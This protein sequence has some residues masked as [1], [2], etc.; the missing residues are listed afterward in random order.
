M[1]CGELEASIKERYGEVKR[2]WHD[3]RNDKHELKEKQKQYDPPQRFYMCC[4]DPNVVIAMAKSRPGAEKQYLNKQQNLR[5]LLQE[6]NHKECYK[7][8]YKT[9][10]GVWKVATDPI[11]EPKPKPKPSKCNPTPFVIPW[12]SFPLPIPS[13]MPMPMPMPVPIPA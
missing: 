7:K 12:P 3:L 2:R 5:D 6:F 1:D 13:P 11:P 8:G 4:A 10:E 9:P